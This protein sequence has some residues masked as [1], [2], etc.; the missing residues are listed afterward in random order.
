MDRRRGLLDAEFGVEFSADLGAD[1]GAGLGA[2]L[3]A[4]LGADLGADLG[5]ELCSAGCR[6]ESSS[7][8]DTFELMSVLSALPPSGRRFTRD[9]SVSRGHCP[10]TRGERGWN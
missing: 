6:K 1:L 3:S 2:G 5:A 7:G 4:G 8:L 9:D 10:L